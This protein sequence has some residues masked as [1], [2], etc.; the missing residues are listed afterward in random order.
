MGTPEDE[1]RRRLR[2][3]LAKSKKKYEEIG[4]EETR[5]EYARALQAFARSVRNQDS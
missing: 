4:D 1:L 2:E 3:K 5:E